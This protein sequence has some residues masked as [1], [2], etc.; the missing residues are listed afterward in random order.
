[1]AQMSLHLHPFKTKN[2]SNLIS[3]VIKTCDACTPVT[4]RVSAIL[5]TGIVDYEHFSDVRSSIFPFFFSGIRTNLMVCCS[6]VLIR[7][8]S[9]GVESVSM[10]LR[11]I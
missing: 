8:Y 5:L 11:F 4:P 10:I 7:V 1:M 2:N 6:F 3:F 9:K